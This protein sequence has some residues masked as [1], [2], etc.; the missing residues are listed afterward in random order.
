MDR[1]DLL[2]SAGSRYKKGWYTYLTLFRAKLFELRIFAYIYSL[3][4]LEKYLLQQ[5]GGIIRIITHKDSTAADVLRSFIHALVRVKLG[6]QDGSM[7]SESQL[8]MDK[9][10]EV[11]VLKVFVYTWSPF[12]EEITLYI[13]WFYKLQLLKHSQLILTNFFTK[14]SLAIFWSKRHLNR[15]MF[16]Y[17]KAHKLKFASAKWKL[18]NG[19]RWLISREISRGVCKLARALLLSKREKVKADE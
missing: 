16:Q 17:E 12:R 14:I 7:S 2:Q 6:D 1:V 9:H 11:F 18:A 5:K 19:G 8:W 13:Y 10:Y 4:F 3:V 15:L